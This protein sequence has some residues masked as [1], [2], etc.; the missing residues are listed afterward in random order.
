MILPAPAMRHGQRG[1][2]GLT[3]PGEAAMRAELEKEKS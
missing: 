1:A 2:L 3:V